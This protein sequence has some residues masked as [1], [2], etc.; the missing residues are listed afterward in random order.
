LTRNITY[1]GLWVAIAFV[2]SIIFHQF[3]SVVG[4]VLL[5][6]H[7][8]VLLAGGISGPTI[9]AITG[10]L[11]PLLTAVLFGRPPLQPPIAIFMAFELL[12]YGLTMGLL[13]KKNLY[14]AVAISWIPGRIIYGIGILLIAPMLGIEMGG[15][16][17]LLVSFAMGIPG[18]IIQ[19]WLIPTIIKRI[20]E[21]SV[22]T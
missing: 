20:P 1:L 13:R 4:Q 17:S 10:L 7:F 2:V 11:S 12:A 15:F 19:L 9:G 22:N 21:S 18:I 14:F 5:P 3:S 8:V 6:L 16:Q